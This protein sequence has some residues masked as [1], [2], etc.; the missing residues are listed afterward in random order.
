MQVPRLSLSGHFLLLFFFQS[1]CTLIT[2]A[3]MFTL[4]LLLVVNWCMVLDSTTEITPSPSP[5]NFDK[6]FEISLIPTPLKLGPISISYWHY[7]QGFKL[8]SK[9]GS[10]HVLLSLLLS[11]QIESNPGPRSPKYPCGECNKAVRWG[12]SIACDQCDVWYHKDCLQMTSL[13]FEA[14]AD[15]SWICCKCA[16]PNSSSLF[17]SFESRNSSIDS[18]DSPGRPAHQSSP[19]PPTR[20]KNSVRRLKIQ[21]INFDSLFAKRNILSAG[22]MNE[23]PDIIIGSETHLDQTIFDN[24]ILPQNYRAWRNDRDRLGGGL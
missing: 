2:N 1:L 9:R 5:Y 24:E 17:D 16:L 19:V 21:V 14:Q 6:N 22:I 3:I 20:K 12:K 4:M 15:L 7:T 23:D 11:G 10:Y 8:S 18:S 13:N